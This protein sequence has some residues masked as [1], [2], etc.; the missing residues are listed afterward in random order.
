[1]FHDDHRVEA[2]LQEPPIFHPSDNRLAGD[3]DMQFFLSWILCYKR[4]LNTRANI[5]IG[6]V[7]I[8]QWALS[9]LCEESFE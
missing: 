8:F 5:L 4:A 1:M 2:S 6:T 9:Y 3:K 7:L